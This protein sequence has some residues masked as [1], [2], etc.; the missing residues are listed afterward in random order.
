MAIY[1][2]PLK[3]NVNEIIM[4]DQLH[5]SAIRTMLGSIDLDPFSSDLA[6]EFIQAKKYLTPEDDSLNPKEPWEGNVYVYPFSGKCVYDKTEQRWKRSDAYQPTM[7]S[8]LTLAF[9]NLYK[10]YCQ[11]SVNQAIFMTSGADLFFSQQAIFRFPICFSR[12]PIYVTRNNGKELSPY[13]LSYFHITFLPPKS[14]YREAVNTFYDLYSGFGHV[15]M[16]DQNYPF[17]RF[18]PGAG[19]R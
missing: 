4:S 18:T 5:L 19:V 9:K 12:S 1:N 13:R 7:T 17:K 3:S 6:N 15:V 2:R 11:G 10:F 16:Q 14:G 8:A